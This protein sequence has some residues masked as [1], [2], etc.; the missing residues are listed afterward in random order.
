MVLGSRFGVIS[1]Q[2]LKPATGEKKGAKANALENIAV[3]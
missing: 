2:P 1:A 3:A